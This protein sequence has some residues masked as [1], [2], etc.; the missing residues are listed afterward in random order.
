[1]KRTILTV[2][3]AVVMS[4]SVS[5]AD[6]II[7]ASTLVLKSGGNV[8]GTNGW[9]LNE[10]GYAGAFIWVPNPATINVSIQAAGQPAGGV[11]PKM[12]L[13]IANQKA[14]WDVTGTSPY[15]S[16]NTYSANF[17]L[18]RGLFFARIEFTNDYASGTQDRNLYLRSLSV[19]GGAEI[20]NTITANHVLMAADSYISY[21]RQ[22]S[23]KLNLTYGKGEN[24]VNE[25]TAV[26]VKLKKHQF[27]FA[28]AVY[29]VDTVSEPKL[30]ATWLKPVSLP[31]DYYRKY[32]AS[33]F[34]AI[35]LED[36]GK[37]LW[38]EGTRDVL[39]METVDAILA[40]ANQ[41]NMDVR[42]HALLYGDIGWTQPDWVSA[43]QNVALSGNLTAKQN[44][45]DEIS[46]RI[47]YY[48]TDRVSKFDTF[49]VINEDNYTKTHSNLFGPAGLASIFNEARSAAGGKA[50]MITNEA[51]V[52]VETSQFPG[53]VYAN[54]YKNYLYRIMQ[55][56]GQLD[57]VGMQAHIPSTASFDV[58]RAFKAIQNMAVLDKDLIITEFSCN[59]DGVGRDAS[60]IILNQIMRLAFG[61]DRMTEFT[62]WSWYDNYGWWPGA[63]HTDSWRQTHPAGA[64]HDRLMA[65]WT[66]NTTAAASNAGQISFMGFYGD[67]E[68]TV[69][70]QKKVVK[71]EQPGTYDVNMGCIY[72]EVLFC[73]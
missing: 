32:L 37:W 66:T 26:Q 62:Q 8:H 12:D 28:A 69:N 16:Y 43:L 2:C 31:A 18:P 33:R 23:F 42:M 25:N 5:L 38:N 19:T 11:Y 35:V 15:T 44:Y 21:C 30:G 57:G 17:S 55:Q 56:G 64:E 70:G 48:I 40:W 52:L 34:N 71:L 3:A 50:K 63:A 72:P 10:I 4:S 60:S 20:D 6:G 68:I 13:H 41:N 73:R 1:M 39:T 54:W 65:Q 67:Y 9:A 47:Q 58:V 61:T 27:R 24:L 36:G 7:D 29:G 51:S 22:G 53:D 14:S 49:E 46:E 59:Y 45:R